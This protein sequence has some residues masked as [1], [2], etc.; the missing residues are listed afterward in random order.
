MLNREKYEKY[1]SN[2]PQDAVEIS[3]EGGNHA[4]FGSYGNQEG[5]GTASIIPQQQVQIT[6]DALA[7]FFTE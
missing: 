7:A 5:D 4:Y 3:I 6:A 1:R 2:L